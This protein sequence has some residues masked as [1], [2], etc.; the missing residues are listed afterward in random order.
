[1]D[2]QCYSHLIYILHIGVALFSNLYYILCFLYI[3]YAIELL[4]SPDLY[5][6]GHPFRSLQAYL[7]YL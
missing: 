7:S 2:P 3:L 1:M 6:P 5:D 4:Q